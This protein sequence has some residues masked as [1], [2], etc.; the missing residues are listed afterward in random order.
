MQLSPSTLLTRG[1]A[2][3][4]TTS[5]VP[6]PTGALSKRIVGN[7][8]PG[9]MFIACPAYLYSPWLAEEA[10]QEGINTTPIDKPQPGIST[11]SRRTIPFP[12]NL[13][14]F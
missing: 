14:A 2:L 11:S 12:A 1:L 8:S 5:A 4:Q 13:A 6:A 3:V 10:I 9:D 7:L